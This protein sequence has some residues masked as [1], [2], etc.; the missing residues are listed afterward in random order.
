MSWSTI[1]FINLGQLK[2]IKGFETIC[3][4]WLAINTLSSFVDL[5]IVEI[6]VNRFIFM[7]NL[8]FCGFRQIICCKIVHVDIGFAKSSSK[9]REKM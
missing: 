8:F 6:T 4:I 2:I 5:C 7:S 1:F 3:L 9:V